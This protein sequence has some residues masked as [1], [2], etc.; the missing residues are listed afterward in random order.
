MAALSRCPGIPL[1]RKSTGRPVTDEHQTEYKARFASTDNSARYPFGHGL[2][3]TDFVLSDLKLSDTAL[4]WDRAIAISAKVTN[5][6]ARPGSETVQ[7]YIRDRVATRTRPVRELKRIERVT[8]SPGESR[9]VRFSLS[10]TDLEFVG[11]HNQRL[12]EPGDFDLWLGQ[13]SE[14]GLHGVFTLFAEVGQ[15]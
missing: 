5:K 11:A 3:Y 8:L 10:R 2:S 15:G 9:T 6:G 7:L 1:L 13:S 14:G 12:A 4:R